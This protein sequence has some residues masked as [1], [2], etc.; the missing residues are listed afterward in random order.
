MN[1]SKQRAVVWSVSAAVALWAAAVTSAAAGELFPGRFSQGPVLI[2][3]GTALCGPCQPTPVVIQGAA[4]S[5]VVA[6]RHRWSTELRSFQHVSTQEVGVTDH[7]GELRFS[8]EQAK[9]SLDR[10]VVAV[11][12][13]TS[14]T[15]LFLTHGACAGPRLC[16]GPVPIHAFANSW[17]YLPGQGVVV[18]V[19][20][21]RPGT[22]LEIAQEEYAGE[23]DGSVWIPGEA[24][25]GEVD[26]LGAATVVLPAP[27]PGVY[28]AL[29]R[30]PETG[31][32]STFALYEVTEEPVR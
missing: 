15:I 4:G 28:R 20:G 21:A 18:T 29:A 3:N 27:G 7:Q 5:A 2:G 1:E 22:V 25:H 8:V 26:A 16:P 14:N 19:T 24:T 17:R 11:A 32:E 6:V 10:L 9:A 31:Q 23:D 13:G 30:D 12:D